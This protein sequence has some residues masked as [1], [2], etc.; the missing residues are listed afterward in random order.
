MKC[1]KSFYSH[2][3]SKCANV[4]HLTEIMHCC[5]LYITS[6]VSITEEQNRLQKLSCVETLDLDLFFNF[7][8]NEEKH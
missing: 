8:S 4:M 1:V 2:G 3:G 6:D 5:C 7:G